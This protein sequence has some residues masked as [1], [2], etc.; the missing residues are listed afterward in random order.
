MSDDDLLERLLEKWQQARC[1]GVVITPET[2]C[3]D[4]SDLLREL[5]L[6]ILL[7]FWEEGADQGQAPAPQIL[8]E[9]WPDLLD[10]LTRRV[11]ALQRVNGWVGLPA[12]V[13]RTEELQQMPQGRAAW[14]WSRK[15][16]GLS[17]TNNWGAVDR[18]GF[19]ARFSS[20]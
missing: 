3:G 15:F 14:E 20:S 11:Q 8:C 16:P 1:D 5:R 13:A 19:I 7:L 6:R 12:T 17:C 2:L 4:R 18:A 10:E 9:E